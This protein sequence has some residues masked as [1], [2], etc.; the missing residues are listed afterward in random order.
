M[1]NRRASLLD[2][3][4]TACW[5]VCPNCTDWLGLFLRLARCLSWLLQRLLW[6]IRCLLCALFTKDDLS[7]PRNVRVGDLLSKLLQIGFDI[8][9][10][11]FQ[12]FVFVW[13][14]FRAFL[15]RALR[16]R[17]GKFRWERKG[18]KRFLGDFVD[19]LC[20]ASGANRQKDQGRPR[21][22]CAT[23]Y[24]PSADVL[25]QPVPLTYHTM[26]LISCAN[27]L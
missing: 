25:R 19:V 26:L 18:P 12:G 4:T 16:T 10:S 7:V 27:G 3:P 23:D 21:K 24:Q 6:L 5:M 13:H 20:D 22:A 11:L 14:M 9:D 17:K 15:L 8:G 2:C 1:S